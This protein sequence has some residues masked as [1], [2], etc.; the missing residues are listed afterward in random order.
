MRFDARVANS[1]VQPGATWSSNASTPAMRLTGTLVCRSHE[2][3][4][5]VRDHLPLHV[6][7]TRAEPGC[8]SFQ[9]TPTADPLVWLVEERFA[10]H[11]AFTE[12]QARGAASQWGQATAGIERHYEIT[13]PQP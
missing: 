9:V 12:H 13:G 8:E 11:V 5:V 10:D 3:A 7:L 6:S 4:A 1:D 2:E